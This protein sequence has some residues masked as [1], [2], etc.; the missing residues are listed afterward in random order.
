LKAGKHVLSEK[1][2]AENLK[3][4][5]HIIK[6]YS[7]NIDQ[8]KVTWGVAENFRFLESFKYTSQEI[9]RLG[10]I[11]GFQVKI[12]NYV[13]PGNQWYGKYLPAELLHLY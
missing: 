12:F 4:A 11:L 13:A 6:F 1:P 7:E 5:E 2:V 9:E 10:K 8:S 3:D